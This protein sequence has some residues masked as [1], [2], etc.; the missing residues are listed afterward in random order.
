MTEKKRS[1]IRLKW[2]YRI[3]IL[4]V[5]YVL[6]I[7]PVLGFVFATDNSVTPI[8]ALL[9]DFIYTPW[10]WIANKNALLGELHGSYVEFCMKLF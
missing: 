9:A 5:V 6:S 3:A 10:F 1:R 2:F 7:G 8:V 4:L